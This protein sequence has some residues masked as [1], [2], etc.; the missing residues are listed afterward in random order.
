MFTII[1]ILKTLTV[2]LII[3]NVGQ[4]GILQIVSW[5]AFY[6]SQIISFVFPI[7][8]LKKLRLKKFN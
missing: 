2:F 6:V 8:Q 3:T 7:L 4:S 5:T 1:K